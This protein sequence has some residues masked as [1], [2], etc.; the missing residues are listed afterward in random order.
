MHPDNIGTKRMAR[1]DPNWTTVTV[2]QLVK[3]VRK[4]E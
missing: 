2:E 1:N 4:C 3:I